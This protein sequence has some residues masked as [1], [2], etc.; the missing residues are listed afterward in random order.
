MMERKANRKRGRE[1]QGRKGVAQGGEHVRDQQSR[2]EWVMQKQTGRRVKGQ[3]P[4][5]TSATIKNSPLDGASEGHE[6]WGSICPD[7]G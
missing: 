7:L 6:G 3:G 1:R 4:G 2:D 5:I